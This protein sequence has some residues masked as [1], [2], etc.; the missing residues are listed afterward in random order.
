MISPCQLRELSGL[1][2]RGF[3]PLQILRSWNESLRCLFQRSLD[4][5]PLRGP[6]TRS[7]GFFSRFSTRGYSRTVQ[8]SSKTRTGPWPCLPDYLAK[9]V[10]SHLRWRQ[11]A[12]CL[13]LQSSFPL[14]ACMLLKRCHG[15]N[16]YRRANPGC[17]YVQ[18]SGTTL[19][20]VDR[21]VYSKWKNLKGLESPHYWKAAPARTPRGWRPLLALKS[22]G[23]LSPQ[24]YTH[25][26]IR[27]AASPNLNRQLCT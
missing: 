15:S 22:L 4:F 12:G 24:D 27:L 18:E 20:Y 26:L 13:L 23:I 17:R 7:R 5:F 14:Q 2:L 25:R 19:L 1:L 11:I 10:I 16:K 6:W 21:N 9:S 3:W 8:N